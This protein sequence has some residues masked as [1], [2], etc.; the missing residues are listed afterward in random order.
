VLLRLG[1]LTAN[2]AFEERGRKNLEVFSGALDEYPMGYPFMLMA[3]DFS[4]GP[5]REV[6]LAGKVDDPDLAH[7]RRTLQSLFLPRTVMALRPES[8]S[9]E[10]VKLI[11][12]LEGQIAV[13][14]KPAAYVCRDYVCELPVT[15]VAELLG[16][17]SKADND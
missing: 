11:P 6:V 10:I 2:S 12:Y 9:E 17:L 15:T 16:L 13:K 7:L 14:G 5:D 3:L 8:G 4:V 1:R